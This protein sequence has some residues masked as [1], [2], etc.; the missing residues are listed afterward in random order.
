[1][2][3]REIVHHEKFLILSKSFK[4][5]SAAEASYRVCMWGRVKVVLKI[6]CKMGNVFAM[7]KLPQC[8]NFSTMA[9]QQPTTFE[10]ISTKS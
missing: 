4:K 1:M 10:I 3:K 5:S 9:Q 8:F 6:V 2:A 7:R